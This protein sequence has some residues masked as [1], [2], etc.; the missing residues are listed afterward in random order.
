MSFMVGASGRLATGPTLR[1]AVEAVD[2]LA[3][4][5]RPDFFGVNCAHPVEFAPSL[6]GG[7]WLERVRSL[8]PAQHGDA[9]RPA[10]W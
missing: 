10:G 7:T 1:E 4:D 5:A 9:V 3:G 6:Y 2:E 8:R